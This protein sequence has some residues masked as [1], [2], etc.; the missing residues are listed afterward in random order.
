MKNEKI[1]RI[2]YFIITFFA[3][4]MRLKTPLP[5]NLASLDAGM[6]HLARRGGETVERSETVETGWWHLIISKIIL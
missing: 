6:K 4:K 3:I 1:S 5:D 2:K